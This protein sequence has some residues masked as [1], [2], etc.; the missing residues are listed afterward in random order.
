MVPVDLHDLVPLH[1][2]EFGGILLQLIGRE[3]FAVPEEVGSVPDIADAVDFLV[4]GRVHLKICGARIFVVF[5][6]VEGLQEFV[7]YSEATLGVPRAFYSDFLIV[8]PIA[9]VIFKEAG[10]VYF[11]L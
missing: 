10:A 3:R 6:V 4:F 11:V 1:L 8:L 2:A 5:R 9:L 7:D